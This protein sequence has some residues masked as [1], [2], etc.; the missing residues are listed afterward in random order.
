VNA[1]EDQGERPRDHHCRCFGRQ[2]RV[3]PDCLGTSVVLRYLPPVNELPHSSFA[4]KADRRCAISKECTPA[5]LNPLRSKTCQP[6]PNPETPTSKLQGE[7]KANAS[8]TTT[9]AAS[10][11][12]PV[13]RCQANSAQLRQSRLDSG[14]GL[15]HFSG[16]FN[17]SVALNAGRDKGER[18]CDHHHRCVGRYASVQPDC[19]RASVVLR[20]LPPAY[21]LYGV[22]PHTGG[23]RELLIDNLL[24]RVKFIIV[25]IRWTGL[26]SREFE[27]PFFRK[28]Y[29]DLPGMG[30]CPYSGVNIYTAFRRVLPH[31]IR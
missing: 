19:I 4:Q 26:A 16:I 1:G 3:Q 10:D 22:S 18:F 28:P 20:D 2:V 17:K 14:P 30:G 29:I 27:F 12:Q 13:Y 11:D 9:I 8:V 21:L 15:S 31:A 25:M 5:T 7:I 6:Y 24:M 23:E